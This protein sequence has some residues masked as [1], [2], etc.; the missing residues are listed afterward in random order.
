MLQLLLFLAGKFF[1]L[2]AGSIYFKSLSRPYKLVFYLTA[3]AAVVEG[4]GF[5]IYSVLK[6]PNIWL[7]NFYLII[8]VWLMGLAAIYL[9]NNKKIRIIFY[10]LLAITTIV[11]LLNIYLTSIYRFAN[12]AMICGCALLTIMYITVLLDNSIFSSKEILKQP[13][14]WLAISSIIY[15]ACDIPLMGLFNF[16]SVQMPTSTVMK[17]AL[18]NSALDIIR[19]PIAGV[20]FILLGRQ[21]KAELKTA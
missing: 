3:I 7:F 13:V 16:L 18:I 19:Y 9:I 11:W 2:I 20:S 1:A 8:E 6:Q 17:L 4:Y 10:A 5:Y 14:F 12:Y 15:F 21:K